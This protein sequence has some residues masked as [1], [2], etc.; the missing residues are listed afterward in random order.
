MI[1]G[2]HIVP[3]PEGMSPEQAWEESRRAPT[4]PFNVPD[5]GTIAVIE[6]DGDHRFVR[7]VGVTDKP[8]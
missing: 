6:V 3:V 4:Q 1:G 7:L 2:I 5:G 8:V